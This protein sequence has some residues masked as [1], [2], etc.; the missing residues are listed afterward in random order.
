MLLERDSL[1]RLVKLHCIGLSPFL[2]ALCQYCWLLLFFFLQM[3]TECQKAGVHVYL[4]NCNGKAYPSKI[5][6]TS[7]LLYSLFILLHSDFILIFKGLYILKFTCVQWILIN[8]FYPLRERL[9]DPHI[10]WSNELH[11]PSTYFRYCSWCRD[12]HSTTKGKLERSIVHKYT[13][14]F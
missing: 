2:S 4:A 14:T 13:N 5:F 10:K 8:D 1:H 7:S 9:K 12:V 6:L 3:C 11:E